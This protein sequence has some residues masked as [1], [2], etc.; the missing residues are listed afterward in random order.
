MAINWSD[1]YE[2]FIA[3]SILH[4][5]VLFVAGVATWEIIVTAAFDWSIISGRRK[6]GWPMALYFVCR[7]C[8]LLGAWASAIQNI[9]FNRINCQA[10]FL[11][12]K[13]IDAVGTCTSS[14]ILSLRA[15]AVWGRDRRI[16]STLLVLWIGQVALWTYMS[17]FWIAS[18]NTKLSMCLVVSK[19]AKR[20]VYV[21]VFT[22]NMVF[23]AVILLLMLVKLLGHNRK[24][25]I[26]ALLL[27]DG[28]MYFIASVLGNGS[29]TVFAALRLNA[30]MEVMSI[31]F[32]ALVSTIAATRLFAHAF[33]GFDSLP[34]RHAGAAQ[35]IS[36][37]V[38]LSGI[39]TGQGRS[40]TVIFLLDDAQGM[41]VLST[42]F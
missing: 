36:S 6:W 14:V 3:D 13:T 34:N 39:S 35:D 42:Q 7:I 29:E 10:V 1:P 16:G 2:L 23:D 30:I 4:G 28:I 25:S 8:L 41:E 21:T 26:S 11:V 24:G 22:Y 37:M 9:A 40:Q 19:P 27:K 33:E 38:F 5:L 17:Y 15:Y 31:S 32:S 12:V 20:W 18:W